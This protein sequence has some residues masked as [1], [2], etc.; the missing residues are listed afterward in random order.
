MVPRIIASENASIGV[1]REAYAD[2]RGP[3]VA[4]GSEVRSV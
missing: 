3:V 2:A 4:A 1:R